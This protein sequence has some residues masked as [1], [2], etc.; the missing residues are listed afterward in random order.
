MHLILPYNMYLFQVPNFL[1][2]KVVK[3][4]GP[5]I[6]AN[7]VYYVDIS[8]AVSICLSLDPELIVDC[9]PFLDPEH[10]HIQDIIGRFPTSA[11][12]ELLQNMLKKKMYFT[13]VDEISIVDVVYLH[14]SMQRSCPR[15]KLM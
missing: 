6:C 5:S 15:E 7:I 10:P 2:S 14:F 3:A 13:M 1:I 4:M 9:S 11:R 12:V 8:S